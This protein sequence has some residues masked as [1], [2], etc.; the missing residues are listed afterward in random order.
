MYVVQ[1]Q[2][3]MG[4]YVDVLACQKESDAVRYW[5]DNKSHDDYRILLK[6]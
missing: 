5:Q 3:M 2:A 1:K 6:R 4:E